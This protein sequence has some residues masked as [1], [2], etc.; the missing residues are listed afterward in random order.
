MALS[1]QNSILRAASWAKAVAVFTERRIELWLQDLQQRLLDQAI[2]NRWNSQLA[3]TA[4]RFG[5]DHTS[6]RAGPV[7]A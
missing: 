1:R 3:L 5:D 7:D 6:Y 4:V 2:G